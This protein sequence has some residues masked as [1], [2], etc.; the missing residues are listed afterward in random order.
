MDSISGGM[1]AHITFIFNNIFFLF[2]CLFVYSQQL[3]FESHFTVNEFLDSFLIAQNTRMKQK[4]KK[5]KPINFYQ[6]IWCFLYLLQK[7][8]KTKPSTAF[9]TFFFSF[10]Y[11][12]FFRVYLV[13]LLLDKEL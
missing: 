8:N 4:M 13:C 3:L 6:R 12:I 11:F 2:V 5:L 9:G 10:K 7:M 1:E